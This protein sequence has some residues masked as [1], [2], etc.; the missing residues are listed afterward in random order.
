MNNFIN[1]VDPLVQDNNELFHAD[2]KM[3]YILENKNIQDY[4]N[5]IKDKQNLIKSE[6][7]KDTEDKKIEN[8][9]PEIKQDY[10]YN[11]DKYKNKC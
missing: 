3:H 4:L 6:K 5:Y 7:K 9:R 8:I 1:A 2:E 11:N 10:I